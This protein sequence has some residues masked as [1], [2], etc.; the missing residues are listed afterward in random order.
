MEQIINSRFS[1]SQ[2][3][4]K[5][6]FSILFIAIATSPARADEPERYCMTVSFLAASN[7][8]DASTKSDARIDFQIDYIKGEGAKVCATKFKDIP[9]E[10]GFHHEEFITPKAIYAYDDIPENVLE[11][12]NA[13]ISTI[14][15]GERHKIYANIHDLDFLNFNSLDEYKQFFRLVLWTKDKQYLYYTEY[16]NADLQQ[17]QTEIFEFTYS[18]EFV[19]F[20]DYIYD[21]CSSSL[22]GKYPYRLLRNPKD[23]D[24][25]KAAQ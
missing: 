6:I 3:I 15:P 24:A 1:V 25:L 18:P 16:H 21:I 22:Q 12:L 20:M 13:K 17:Q 2:V 8:D 5:F 14:F 11:K 10:E 9:R 23:W 19:D 7:F 4:V